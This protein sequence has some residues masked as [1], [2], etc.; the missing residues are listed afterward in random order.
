MEFKLK[1]KSRKKYEWHRWYAWHP[2]VIKH[3]NGSKSVVIG[4]VVERKFIDP[5][6]A[7]CSWWI[8]RF[9]NEENYDEKYL[10]EYRLRSMV[11]HFS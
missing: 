10:R 11:K 4:K 9:I 5:A 1:R 2:I 6:Y 8:Y 3:E 7:E